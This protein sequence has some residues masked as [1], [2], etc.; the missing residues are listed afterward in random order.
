M[1]EEV[2]EISVDVIDSTIIAIGHCKTED[3]EDQAQPSKHLG[4]KSYGEL[5]PSVAGS[6][7]TI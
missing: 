4:K 1:C 2:G 5:S 6:S 3:S 7:N